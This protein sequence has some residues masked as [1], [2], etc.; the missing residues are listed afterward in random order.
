MNEESMRSLES[1]GL[2][3]SS[4][5]LPIAVLSGGQRQGVAI[6]RALHFKAKLVVLDVPTIAL[7]VK[8]SQ[9]VLVFIKRLKEEGISVIFITHN[10]HHVFPVAD[11]FVVL[12]RGEKTADVKKGEMSID[13]LTELIVSGRSP[14]GEN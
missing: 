11:R 9:E 10:L 8:E 6:A 14:G 2:R 12:T 4:P 5:D 13:E 3:L 1:L 7:S